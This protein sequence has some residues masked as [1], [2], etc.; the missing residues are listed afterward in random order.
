[1]SKLLGLPIVLYNGLAK[2]IKFIDPFKLKNEH[3]IEIRFFKATKYKLSLTK[4]KLPIT[5]LK[6]DVTKITP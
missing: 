4:K 3:Q 2:I 6:K 1:M 5:L